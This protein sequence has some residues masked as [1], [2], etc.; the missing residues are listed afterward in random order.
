[1]IVIAIA[2]ELI[3]KTRNGLKSDLF[4]LNW[5]T[6]SSGGWII[7]ILLLFHF[8]FSGLSLLFSII[9]IAQD[10]IKN[11]DT[12]IP[13]TGLQ[14]V[15]LIYYRVF[16]VHKFLKYTDIT[17]CTLKSEK[18]GLRRE[19]HHSVL[20]CKEQ[21]NLLREKKTVALWQ[22][23]NRLHGFILLDM[24]EM[25]IH[26]IKVHITA[27][28]SASKFN[29]N[30]IAYS[31]NNP[32]KHSNS[33]RSVTGVFIRHVTS[34]RKYLL[35]NSRTGRISAV[36]ATPEH[37]FYVSNRQAFI[38]IAEVSLSDR[39]ITDTGEEVRIIA[40]CQ[41]QKKAGS[42]MMMRLVMSERLKTV[43]NL[44]ISEKHTYFVS[45]LRVFVHNPYGVTTIHFPENG[46]K[47]EGYLI[48][49]GVFRGTFYRS[50]G[51]KLFKGKMTERGP[52]EYGVL[53]D[54]NGLDVY[55]GMWEEGRRCGF[56][57]SHSSP[58]KGCSERFTSYA[59]HWENDQY[60]GWGRKFL[61]DTRKGGNLVIYDGDFVG[62]ELVNGE[63]IG[64]NRIIRDTRLRKAGLC[65]LLYKGRWLHGKYHG[66]GSSFSYD[67]VG[68]CLESRGDFE[69]GKFMTGEVY[70][71]NEQ[72]VA[73]YRDGNKIQ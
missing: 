60:H 72:V 67:L 23:E 44:E 10:D 16:P 52:C 38:P 25:G 35:K 51:T 55:N 70:D 34:V 22:K 40:G 63:Y 17:D 19:N 27:V 64:S 28:K 21:V 69:H 45:D 37:R 32:I 31:V 5:V 15:D 33:V 24:P 47:F 48:D 71:I 12:V 61:T 9:C 66:E 20:I 6:L 49:D 18:G 1:M 36:N 30:N 46:L 54:E 58:K 68:G 3:L 14:E 50:D 56:G 65:Q 73:K 2:E 7:K 4:S 11:I 41:R 59:G 43:Y 8:V 13:E 53:Y 26:H 57:R 42:S 29:D 62:G 39:L